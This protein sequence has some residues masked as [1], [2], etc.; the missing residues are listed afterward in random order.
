MGPASAAD[1]LLQAGLLDH[2]P[3]VVVGE[4]VE[5]VQVGAHGAGP[6]HGLLGDDGQGGAQLAQGQGGDVH[7]VNADGTLV[8]LKHAVQGQQQGGL[9]GT[10]T[11]H[12]TSL[13]GMVEAEGD[14]CRG[15]WERRQ[16]QAAGVKGKPR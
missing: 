2:L 4:L 15:G 10:G 3:Q 1:L 14:T 16:S 11:A 13:L 9:A 12:H 7:T 6:H 8:E 5:G